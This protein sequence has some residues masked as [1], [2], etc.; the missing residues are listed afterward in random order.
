MSR[1][2]VDSDEKIDQSNANEFCAYSRL[3]QIRLSVEFLAG[4]YRMVNTEALRTSPLGLAFETPDIM[5]L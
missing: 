4:V 1:D 5:T 2:V 3:H